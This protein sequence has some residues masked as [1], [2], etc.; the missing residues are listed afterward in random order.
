MCASRRKLA[1]VCTGQPVRA[2]VFCSVVKFPI[3]RLW[4][5]SLMMAPPSAATCCCWWLT[6]GRRAANCH[7]KA[8]FGSQC[9]HVCVHT[10]ALS[11]ACV[12]FPVQPYG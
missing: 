3:A 11:Y 1:R 7:S 12:W 8:P 4:L 10:A 6:T 5:L 2:S 9:S